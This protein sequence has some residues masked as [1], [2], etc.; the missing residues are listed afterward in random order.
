VALAGV[1]GLAC[2]GDDG[3]S[4]AST[5]SSSSS[6][7]GPATSTGATTTTSSTSSA[8][9]TGL[10]SSSGEPAGPAVYPLVDEPYTTLQAVWAP[11]VPSPETEAAIEAGELT[12][13]DHHRFA[14]HG[15]GVELVGGNPW[16]E[17]DELAPGFVAGPPA[18]R[19]SLV[20][21]WQSADSQLIDEESPIR[22]EAV[23]SIYRPHGHLSTQVFEAHVR[24]AQR[25]HALGARGLDFA[26]VAGDMTD[27]GQHNELHWMIDT[28][29]GGVID[30]DSGIDDDPVPG[31]GND[32]SDPFVSD[33]LAV[34]WYAALGNHETLYNGGFGALTDEV[35]MAAMG[36]EV[37]ESGL[38]VNGYCDGS[39]ENAE[40]R[41][42]GS[43][44]PD[45]D[46]IPLR[47]PE[48][49]E[50]LHE[51]P[52][53]PAGHGL[54]PQHVTEAIGYFSVHPI[55]GR[56]VRLVVL[57][58][59]HH[60]AVSPGEGVE[61]YVDDEQFAWLTTTLAE[62][63]AALELVIVVSHHRIADFSNQSPVSGAQLAEA[64]ASTPGMVLHLTGHGHANRSELQAPIM[65]SPEQ[66]YW[67][68]MLASTVDFPM[69]TRML[70][71]VDEGTGFLSIYV[72]NLEH[73]S[74][75][76]SLA[77]HGRELAAGKGAFPGVLQPADVAGQWAEDV[78]HQNLL[79]RVAIPD[80]LRDALATFEWPTA[81]ASEETLL[82]LTGP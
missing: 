35:R 7:G 75:T 51:A 69:H 8:D 76:D 24:S 50:A 26:V 67:E 66:G 21:L 14:E 19:R 40:L 25:L 4:A 10:D 41:T 47:H 28:L 31:P 37:Y 49:L 13:Y 38:F 33:G 64:L 30:P 56:P 79:L 12:V 1:I 55:A 59:V 63:T 20:Y 32:Y 42:S 46:R 58:T 2:A 29:A 68:L 77:H 6:S 52:G 9:A 81:I 62:A 36:D 70:E 60:A 27:G 39:T 82:Q 53:E 34:P 65:A 48:V 22:F 23:E 78:P 43:T 71:I 44:P 80:A 72:T 61:G 17:H 5:T 15:L 16:I 3:S 18:Q 57:D 73:N 11:R 54:T 45:P 74:P